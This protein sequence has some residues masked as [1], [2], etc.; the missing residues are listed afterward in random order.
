MIQFLIYKTL[1]DINNTG[2]TG[3]FQTASSSFDAFPIKL[4][5]LIL[6]AIFIILSFVSYNS[7]IRRRGFGDFVASL[8]VAGLV[9]VLIAVFMSFIPNFIATRTIIISIIIEIGLVFWLV[10]SKE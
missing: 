3:M 10:I 4:P 5:E 7:Q 9:M 1:E 6:F 2:L 8:S